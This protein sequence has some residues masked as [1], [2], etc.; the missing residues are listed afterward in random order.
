M[1]YDRSVCPHVLQT[2]SALESNMWWDGCLLCV[3]VQE[4][5]VRVASPYLTR[6]LR[7]SLNG[8]DFVSGVTTQTKNDL[9]TSVIVFLSVFMLH[10]R[11]YAYTQEMN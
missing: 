5:A 6:K 9:R 11:E 10:S 3:C 7:H 1:P 2:V 8:A 4:H